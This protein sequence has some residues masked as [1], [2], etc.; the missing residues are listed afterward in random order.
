MVARTHDPVSASAMASF[1]I[2]HLKLSVDFC[3]ENAPDPSRVPLFRLAWR[4]G[5]WLRVHWQPIE[6]LENRSLCNG[7]NDYP[8]TMRP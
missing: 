5:E 2:L 6:A 8:E 7:L 3:C 1:F 4:W